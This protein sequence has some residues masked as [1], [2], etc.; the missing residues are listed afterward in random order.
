[1]RDVAK[2][3][4]EA[5]K[6]GESDWMRPDPAR[7]ETLD[8]FQSVRIAAEALQAEAKLHIMELHRESQTGRQLF[9]A[10]KFTRLK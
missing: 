7:G 9:D 4:Y 10:I 3:A 2:E 6:I 8:S 5:C 1:M